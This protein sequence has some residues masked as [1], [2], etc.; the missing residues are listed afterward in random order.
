MLKD[1]MEELFELILQD[2]EDGIFANSLVAAGAIERDFV[3]FSNEVRFAEVSDEKR[4]VA[5][6]MLIPNKKILQ[7][8]QN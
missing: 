6:P 2:E 3:Y 5:G 8:I 1:S 7:T 4:L